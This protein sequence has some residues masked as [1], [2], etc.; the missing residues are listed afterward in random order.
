MLL[1][2]VAKGLARNLPARAGIVNGEETFGAN[3]KQTQTKQIGIWLAGA[4]HLADVIFWERATERFHKPAHRRM[5]C[6]THYKRKIGSRSS[7][8]RASSTRFRHGPTGTNR[9]Q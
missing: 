8:A 6:S 3:S 5:A 7:P 1:A 2:L 9:I 4:P